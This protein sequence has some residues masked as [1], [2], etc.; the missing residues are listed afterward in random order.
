[1]K[2]WI[3]VAAGLV[4]VVAI[5]AL[6]WAFVAWLAG[7][8]PEPMSGQFAA[9]GEMFGAGSALFAGIGSF[10]VFVVLAFDLRHRRAEYR[11]FV[12]CSPN[13]ATVTKARWSDQEFYFGL[14]LAF[15]I[16]NATTVPA[17]NVGINLAELSWVTSA[18]RRSVNHASTRVDDSPLQ[19]EKPREAVIRFDLTGVLAKEMAKLFE[20]GDSAVVT[21][22]I[23]YK[24][25]NG[26][27]W[28]SQA[29]Y[30]LLLEDGND[31]TLI[32]VAQSPNATEFVDDSDGVG[33]TNPVYFGFEAIAGT[34]KQVQG[35]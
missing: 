3:A 22:D 9:A 7:Y 15:D 27:Y 8:V 4:G 21:V 14:R 35:R 30:L 16:S 25:L 34:W 33:V 1:M 12:V 19:A 11:P 26:T 10:A 20:R 6:S 24:G 13:R 17:L 31:R 28:H 18:D 2:R 23:D 32:G 5:W 29:Q